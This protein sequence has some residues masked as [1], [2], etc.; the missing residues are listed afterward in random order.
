MKITLDMLCV[1]LILRFH[2]NAYTLR[3]RFV[4]TATRV[5]D[6]TSCSLQQVTNDT[7]WPT[8]RAT[9]QS[10][11]TANQVQQLHGKTMD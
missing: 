4:W 8:C 3:F 6:D 10:I 1:M 11:R 2:L 7:D 9:M 5:L